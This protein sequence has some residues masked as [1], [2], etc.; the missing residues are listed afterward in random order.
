MLYIES[1]MHYSRSAPFKALCA[2]L[3][4]AVFID[5]F[6][7]PSRPNQTFLLVRIYYWFSGIK[8]CSRLAA[9]RK[10]VRLFSAQHILAK[11]CGGAETGVSS[12]ESISKDRMPNEI[13]VIWTAFAA[14]N[15][16][17]YLPSFC[18]KCVFAWQIAHSFWWDIAKKL[19]VAFTDN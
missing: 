14:Y 8:S 4:G 2:W 15:S 5:R 12:G 17:K 16:V 10:L 6:V 1:I 13:L 18:T 7:R 9:I 11:V 3:D 19:F